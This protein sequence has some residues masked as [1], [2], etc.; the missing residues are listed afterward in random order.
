MH[1][2]FTIETC[3]QQKLTWRGFWRCDSP[4][5]KKSEYR[6]KAEPRCAASLYWL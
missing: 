5:Q 6:T 3:K 2:R 1:L 4:C